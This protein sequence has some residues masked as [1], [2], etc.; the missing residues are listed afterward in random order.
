MP[1]RVA[2]T[3][4]FLCAMVGGWFC[5]S[6]TMGHLWCFLP[7]SKQF[8]Q[9]PILPLPV[10]KTSSTIPQKRHKYLTWTH[11]CPRKML[12]IFKW[13]H[14]THLCS[15]QCSMLRTISTESS[16]LPRSLNDQLGHR[17][18]FFHYTAVDTSKFVKGCRSTTATHPASTA[19]HPLL[20]DNH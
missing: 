12:T 9:Q 6:Q 3:R 10:L 15:L 13:T 4:P 14:I 18:T 11:C 16:A 7:H 17:Q 20:S 5:H 2:S 8:I 1:W 19:V